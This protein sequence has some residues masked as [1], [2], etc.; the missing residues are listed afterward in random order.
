MGADAARHQGIYPTFVVVVG[1]LHQQVSGVST[2]GAQSKF[3]ESLRI[4]SESDTEGCRR[5][6]RILS[7]S[8][9]KHIDSP[10]YSL[11]DLFGGSW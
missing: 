9:C 4:L 7:A 2:T 3:L 6:V 5:Q 11:G 1:V 8:V 10:I